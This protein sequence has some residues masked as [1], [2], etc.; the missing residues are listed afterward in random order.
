MGSVSLDGLYD[1]AY[2]ASQSDANFNA[3]NK[4]LS[5]LVQ[6]ILPFTESGVGGNIVLKDNNGK[7]G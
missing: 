3:G 2:K 5:N 7:L 1:T 6:Q 4:S